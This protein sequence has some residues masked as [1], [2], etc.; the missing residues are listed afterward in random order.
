MVGVNMNY[1]LAPDAAWPAA[2]DD[3]AAALEWIGDNIA[4]Y[5]GDPGKVVLWGHSA[6]ANHVADY[7]THTE[8]QGDE[9]E[10]VEGAL[11]LSPAY[12]PETGE[13]PHPYYGT[14][15]SLQTAGPAIER[16]GGSGIPIMIGYA[17][18]D[19]AMFQGFA[20][21]TGEQLFGR[22]AE[23]ACPEILFLKDHNHLTE[24]ASIG[25]SDESLSGPFLAWM[26]G[27]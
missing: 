20:E 22:G 25:S 15:A 17:E 10:R 7:V 12:A 8:L 21:Q 16:I 14:N 9:A 26:K 19:P 27:L 3:I 2:R 6:G 24:G 13:N 18:Y 5:G 11:L 23:G 4:E 1:R